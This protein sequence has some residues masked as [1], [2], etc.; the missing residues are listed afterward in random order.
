[1]T[2]ANFFLGSDTSIAL[3]GFLTLNQNSSTIPNK[4]KTSLIEIYMSNTFINHKF[5]ANMYYPYL[6][7]YKAKYDPKKTCQTKGEF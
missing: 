4:C 6:S 3:I 7:I 5:S 1:M 2:I